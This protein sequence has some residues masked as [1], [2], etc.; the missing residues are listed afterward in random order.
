MV[1]KENEKEKKRKDFIIIFCPRRAPF[2]SPT[3]NFPPDVKLTYSLSLSLSLS[4]LNLFRTDIPP[5]L[6]NRK[7][8]R[9]RVVRE[10]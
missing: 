6:Q 7:N 8:A 1:F 2:L 3:E 4:L 10:S 9:D 5:K